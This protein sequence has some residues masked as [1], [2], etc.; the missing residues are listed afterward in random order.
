MK[1]FSCCSQCSG[2][3]S[4]NIFSL[5][6]YAPYEPGYGHTFD[7]FQPMGVA[8]PLMGIPVARPYPSAEPLPIG[9]IPATYRR[10]DGNPSPFISLPTFNGYAETGNPAIFNP[11]SGYASTGNPAIFNPLSGYPS[12]SNPVGITPVGESMPAQVGHPYRVGGDAIGGSVEPL[13]SYFDDQPYNSWS[14]L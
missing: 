7:G 2:G 3:S 11:L 14:R 8:G 1:D 9:S 4:S 5:G 6:A 13:G 12:P 10:G